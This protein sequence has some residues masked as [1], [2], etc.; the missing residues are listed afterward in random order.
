MHEE[1]QSVQVWLEKV[2]AGEP[3]PSYELNQRTVGIL[4]GLMIKNEQRDKDT[5]LII[6]DLRQKSVEYNAEGRRL[7]HLLQAV[8]LTPTSLSQSGITSLRTLANL[9]LLLKLKDT[10]D[11]SYL[12]GLQQL[13]EELSQTTMM[14]ETVQKM[15]TK[16]SQ[17]T[18]T[19]ILKYNS[20]KKALE[21]LEVQS[22]QQYPEQEKR[23]KETGFIHTKTKE[24]RAQIHKYQNYL[25]KTGLDPELYHH[26]LV[27]TSEELKA[28]K[29]EILPLKSK[30][31]SYHSLPPDTSLT[32]VKIE[33]VRQQVAALE[34]ELSK[35]IDLMH[36]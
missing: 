9:A 27:K 34:A 12:L 10:S 16:V 22:A 29:E 7:E 1:H 17:K 19:A 3:V 28:L 33:E 21:N 18:K 13:S 36:M 26:E 11:T 5:M 6:E 4:H 15:I 25:N 23:A 2:F 20:L 30:L 31:Q 35:K 32:K 24:Y 14:R 8:G